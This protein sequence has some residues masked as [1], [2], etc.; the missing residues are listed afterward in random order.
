MNDFQ[1]KP[2]VVVAHLRKLDF[3]KTYAL[4]KTVQP[5][6]RK[7]V[8]Q[9]ISSESWELFPCFKLNEIPL[10]LLDHDRPEDPLQ[11]SGMPQKSGF[12]TFFEGLFVQK[13]HFGA[14]QMMLLSSGPKN[15]SLRHGLTIAE[16]DSYLDKHINDPKATGV[17]PQVSFFFGGNQTTT[18]CKCGVWSSFFEGLSTLHRTFP[19]VILVAVVC[20]GLVLLEKKSTPG[21][22]G[23][24]KLSR[25]IP[26]GEGRCSAIGHPAESTCWTA[27]GA[28]GWISG[29]QKRQ[30]KGWGWDFRDPKKKWVVVSNIFYFQPYLGNWSNFTNIFQMGSNH[31]PENHRKG[32]TLYRFW[33]FQTTTVEIPWFSLGCNLNWIRIPCG[34]WKQGN[35]WKGQTFLKPFGS[36][37]LKPKDS[38]PVKVKRNFQSKISTWW[39]FQRFLFSPLPGETIQFDEHMF[40]M[41][42]FNHQHENQQACHWMFV[43]FDFVEAVVASSDKIIE[44][45]KYMLE[46]GW[47]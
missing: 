8:A 17:C 40:W 27:G 4:L 3:D 42:W 6:W 15:K 21:V 22:L 46:A 1:S 14:K 37:S 31:Q 33:D 13:S 11:K 43:R 39:W 45:H 12:A 47:L 7:F 32:L 36:F 25:K 5:S 35:F 28:E 30:K 34:R 41:G 2:A 18:W 26:G 19:W 20:W 9:S 23:I 29:F 24:W 44:V 10:Y 38:M 16:F